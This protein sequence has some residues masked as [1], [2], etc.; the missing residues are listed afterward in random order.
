MTIDQFKRA[1]VTGF[2]HNN[3]VYLGLENRF[4]NNY[5]L[6]YIKS[7]KIKVNSLQ[8]IKVI[9]EEKSIPYQ[10]AYDNGYLDLD[11]EFKIQGSSNRDKNKLLIKAENEKN[12]FG[13]QVDLDEQ[14]Q[15]IIKYISNILQD[16]ELKEYNE[17]EVKEGNI[18]LYSKKHI[19]ELGTSQDLEKKLTT[20]QSIV[21]EIKDLEG[22]LFL[23][24]YKSDDS[25]Y[26]F[27]NKLK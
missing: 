10:I 11:S 17:I 13:Q 3:P 25:G 12:D 26:R 8:S 23:N 16:L 5:N 18:F 19:I 2:L 6:P 24:E 7:L 20:L 4:R 14:S 9:V 15:N 21:I 22:T 1:V 27:K